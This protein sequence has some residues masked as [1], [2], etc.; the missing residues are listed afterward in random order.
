L[1]QVVWNLVSNAVKFTPD[2]GTVT[3]TLSCLDGQVTQITVRD[4]GAGIEPSFL[5]YVFDRFRQADGSV[6]RRHGGLGLG[7]A[8]VRHIVELHGG[9]VRATSDGPGTGATFIVELPSVPAGELEDRGSL[10]VT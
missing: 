5:P 1:Q 9:T 6:A 7:L 8:I 3:V 4:N 10:E 2:G